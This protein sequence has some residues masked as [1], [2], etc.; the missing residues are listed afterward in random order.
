[1]EMLTS[2]DFTSACELLAEI[3]PRSAAFPARICEMLFFTN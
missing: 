3:K 2:K 1:M